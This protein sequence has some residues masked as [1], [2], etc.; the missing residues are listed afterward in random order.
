MEIE[1][2]TPM[3]DDPI[4]KLA[5]FEAMKVKIIK[6]SQFFS[7][8]FLIF[9]ANEEN[10]QF[11]SKRRKELETFLKKPFYI[12]TLIRIK[13]PDKTMWEAKFT[14]KETLKTVYDLFLTV[15]YFFFYFMKISKN[16]FFFYEKFN[17]L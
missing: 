1:E 11:S 10:L 7:E 17:F 13:L 14:P 15:F 16:L 2:D 5:V 3:T 6:Y 12:E 9:K 8:L 4:L